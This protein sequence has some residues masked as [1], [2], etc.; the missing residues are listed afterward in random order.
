[1]TTTT[2]T[3][4]E[5][6]IGLEV[7]S[8]LLTQSK[9]FCSCSAGYQQA[10]PNTV[11]CPVCMGMPGVLPVVNRKAVEFVMKTGLAL[12]CEIAPYTRFDRK[13]YPY[14]DL[15]KGYQI[16]QQALPIAS[17]GWLEVTTEDVVTKIRIN[18]VHLEED[19]AKLSH[20]TGSNGETYSLMDINRA[21][22]PLMEV[23]SE[24]DMR[25]AEEARAYLIQLRSILRYIG[26]STANME[27]GSF[28][29]DANISVR[30]RGSSELGSKVEV[31]NVNSFKYVYEALKY[32]TER[33][34]KQAR[35][36]QRIVQET[37]GWVEGKNVTA[38]QRTKEEA[39]DYRYFPEPD[40][41]P[42]EI[43]RE[44]MQEVKASL[45]ELPKAREERFVTEYGLSEYDASQLTASKSMAD[46]FEGVLGVK[47][48]LGDAL[49]SRAKAISNWFLSELSRLLNET[50]GD[51]DTVK[52]EPV[53]LHELIDMTDAGTLSS[54]M[55]K[56]VFEEMFKTG[57]SPKAIAEAKGLVQMSDNDA[58]APAADEA[59]ASNPKAVEDYMKG[60][61]T[62]VRFLV[63]QV[64]R[65]TKGKANPQMAEELLLKKLEAFK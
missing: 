22:V 28:R 46:Y 53:A 59:I 26:V 57:E 37:R 64:M 32:E 51:I 12:N 2:A 49:A 21:G 48:L 18:R 39:N 31:K 23:V 7:H 4:Y 36:G 30:P 6:V 54:T 14:P 43:S 15:M 50:G 10:E 56:T 65:I 20:L 34:V 38:S 9:M 45:P 47:S 58:M 3:D 25:S 17:N 35:E 41:P 8:Q 52:F 27:E 44:W 29:C 60:K 24:P 13:N 33:Q 55:A 5:V 63:G 42:I 62:A 19:V 1:M 61:E 16:S 40:L 11:V